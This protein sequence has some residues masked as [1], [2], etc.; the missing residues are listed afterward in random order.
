M[1]SHPDV[2]VYIWD[3][4][5]QKLQCLLWAWSSVLWL[6]PVS[7]APEARVNPWWSSSHTEGPKLTETFSWIWKSREAAGGAAGERAPTQK[8]IGQLHIALKVK[9]PSVWWSANFLFFF[10]FFSPTGNSFY[11]RTSLPGAFPRKLANA[12]VWNVRWQEPTARPA[13]PQEPQRTGLLLQ[14]NFWKPRPSPQRGRDGQPGG[15]RLPGE[16]A[17]D[18]WGD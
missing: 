3:G 9:H 17:S 2:R 11:P 13:V 12:S 16:S 8:F 18:L 15:S 14:R 7:L 10:F 5:S 4:T 6:S 1:I